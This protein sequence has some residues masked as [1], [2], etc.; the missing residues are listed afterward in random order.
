MAISQSSSIQNYWSVSSTGDGT[1]EGQFYIDVPNS[2]L[3]INV[4]AQNNTNCSGVL[5]VNIPAGTL[6]TISDNGGNTVSLEQHATI[7]PILNGT[8]LQIAYNQISSAGFPL[9]TPN[10]TC[11]VNISVKFPPP[12]LYVNP[13][14]EVYSKDKTGTS[15]A[16]ANVWYR[17]N[18]D[19]NNLVSNNDKFITGFYDIDN[20]VGKYL[21]WVGTSATDS[22]LVNY[23]LNCRTNKSGDTY[24][25]CLSNTDLAIDP[26]EPFGGDEQTI[27]SIDFVT[28][29]VQTSFSASKLLQN[30]PTDSLMYMCV[31]NTSGSSTEIVTFNANVSMLNCN[32]YFKTTTL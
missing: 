12:Q 15:L 20:V 27:F 4:I 31:R 29:D 30:I 7:A 2:L 24:E 18:M 5:S 25:V 22:F 21:K 23:N 10:V 3:R 32:S 28:D 16:D 1:I 11:F 14:G 6:F 8:E 17:L 9:T 13:V 19:G 26:P